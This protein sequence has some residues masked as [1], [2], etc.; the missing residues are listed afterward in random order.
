MRLQR[1]EDFPHH[2]QGVDRQYAKRRWA[3]DHQISK[4]VSPWASLSRKINLAPTS[5]RQF[6][7]GGSQI[8]MS[9]T[10]HKL[11]ATCC[12]TFLNSKSPVN[13]S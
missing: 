1:Q 10:S 3:V 2:R 8:E 12:R 4:V 13:T 6:H 11:S 5:P 7:F 9:S